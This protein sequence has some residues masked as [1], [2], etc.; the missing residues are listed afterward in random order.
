NTAS[1]RSAVTFIDG[2]K[3][4]LRYRGYRVDELAEKATWMETAYLILKGELPSAHHLDAWD[5][6]IKKHTFVHENVR[7]LLSGFRYDAHPI[8]MLMVGVRT[9]STFEPEAKTLIPGD[10]LRRP[11]P[12][13]IA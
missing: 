7:A 12:R 1:C 5:Q 9:P 10:P 8:G 3:G 11:P 13:L 4:I 6:S 2:D